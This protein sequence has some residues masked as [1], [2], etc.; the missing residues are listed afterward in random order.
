MTPEDPA[1]A[2]AS[3]TVAYARGQFL[4][5]DEPAIPIE[6]RAHQFGDGIYE[7][8]RVYG[9]HPFLLDYHLER[10]EKSAAAIRIPLERPMPDLRSLL[11]EAIRR[12]PSP[13]AQLYFQLSRG[14]ATRRDHPFPAVKSHLSLTV[15]P[16]SDSKYAALRQFGQNVILADDIR[17]KLCYIKTLNL[18][19][20]ALMKQRALDA[21]AHDAVFVSD[22]VI[23]EATSSNVM[24]VRA[25]TIYTHPATER[26]LHGVTRR[27]LLEIAAEIGIPAREEPFG[28]E[29]FLAADELFTTS[30]M[31]ELAPIVQVDGRRVGLSAL[32]PSS[33]VRR[34][35]QAY[36]DRVK[37][38]AGTL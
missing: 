21:G 2:D 20:N 26:I 8:V 23:T 37:Y 25:G 13:D 27:F 28:K 4:P 10:F 7:A 18:L 15:R 9:G 5:V 35:Q 16:L 24:I 33:V 34:L 29:E 38:A 17:W 31:T 22:G 36:R 11:F 32:A 3:V 6:D 14:F 12:C 30:T 1:H 19:P